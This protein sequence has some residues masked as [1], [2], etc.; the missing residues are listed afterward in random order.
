MVNISHKNENVKPATIF[1]DSITVT[2]R[3]KNYALDKAQEE[4]RTIKLLPQKII[5]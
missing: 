3:R 4:K 5:S 1:D 2:K